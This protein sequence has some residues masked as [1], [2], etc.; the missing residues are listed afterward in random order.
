MFMELGLP[1]LGET[2]RTFKDPVLHRQTSTLETFGEPALRLLERLLSRLDREE[3]GIGLAANQI[4]IAKK[5]FA[6]D[7][8]YIG[9]WE[10][11]RG[12]VFNP[13][14]LEADGLSPYR[15]GCLSIPGL[16]WEIWRPSNVYVEGMDV[17]G[18]V[19]TWELDGLAARLF[20]HEIDHLNGVLLFDRIEDRSERSE[21]MAAANNLLLVGNE[22]P[23]SGSGGKGSFL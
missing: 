18:N 19:C 21:A 16:Y 9:G 20:Q 12:V 3:N 5:A 1:S 4:G 22:A 13:K 23:V 15:E 14:I 10:D 7:L 11:F 6:Y 8:S 17:D 2:I